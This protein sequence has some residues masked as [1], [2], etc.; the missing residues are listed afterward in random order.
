MATIENLNEQNLHDLVKR[1]AR[2]AASTWDTSSWREENQ[3]QAAQELLDILAQQNPNLRVNASVWAYGHAW[4]STDAVV[5][6]K[7]KLL[8]VLPEWVTASTHD[9]GEVAD[10]LLEKDYNNQT[11]K[12]IPQSVP[13]TKASFIATS[14]QA[15]RKSAIVE[16]FPACV[17]AEISSGARAESEKSAKKRTNISTRYAAQH[18][19]DLQSIRGSFGLRGATPHAK[20]ERQKIAH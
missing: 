14:Q 17:H 19:I 11:H 9:A 16:A 13:F 12:G 18:H 6:F 2:T 7:K 5:A 20:R 10:R 15:A 3:H 8:A 1:L 4:K